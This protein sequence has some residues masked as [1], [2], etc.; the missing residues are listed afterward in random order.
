MI[1]YLKIRYIDILK[2]LKLY[3]K[4][5]MPKWNLFIIMVSDYYNRD[6]L[7]KEKIKILKFLPLLPGFLVLSRKKSLNY[8]SK[9]SW[10]I[11]IA[12]PSFF[13]KILKNKKNYYKK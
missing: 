10:I 7:K 6:I 1:Y 11:A 3:K 5:I 4:N 12:L 2:F 13:N 9:Y 8:L